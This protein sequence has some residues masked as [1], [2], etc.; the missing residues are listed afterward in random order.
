LIDPN[1]LAAIVPGCRTL[2]QDGPDRYRAEV[3]IGVAGI[4]GLYKAEIEL[5]D[6]REP[7]SVRLV[8]RASGA[9]GFGAGEGDVTLNALPDGGTRLA[10]R[11]RADVGGKVA[12]VGQRMLGTVTRLLI[13]EFFRSLERRIA[14]ARVS[15]WRRLFRW[16]T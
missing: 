14:P 4:R 7:S 2:T 1:E 13:A 3:L 10:Y 6:K 16:K 15:V 8:A 11:Y 12:A 5:H 9:L